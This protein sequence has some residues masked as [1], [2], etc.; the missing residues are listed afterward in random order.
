MI[1]VILAGFATMFVGGT[2]YAAETKVNLVGAEETPAV[3]TA[4]KGSGMITVNNDKSVSG[5]VTTTGLN[6]TVAHI[7]LGAEGKKGPP[8]INLV[9]SGEGSWSVPSGSVLTDDQYASYKAG[10]L[11]VNV[12]TA[13]NKDGEIRGQLKP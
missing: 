2:I 8:I 10:N 12:H 4:A 11:Y 6:G 13:E 7:H 5:M 1:T 9:K 3:K